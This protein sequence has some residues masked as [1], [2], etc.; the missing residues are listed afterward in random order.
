MYKIVNNLAPH[1][2]ARNFTPVR[3]IHPYETAT[4]NLCVPK[5]NTEFLK[6]SL[7]FIGVVAWNAL[8]KEAKQAK[9]VNS[10]KRIVK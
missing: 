6:S 10:F 2:L 3:Q 1:S 7:P 4:I 5:P 8:P 9:D